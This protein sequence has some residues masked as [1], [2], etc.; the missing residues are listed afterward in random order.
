MDRPDEPVP[1]WPA[2]GSL[3]VELRPHP[4]DLRRGGG[5]ATGQGTAVT[6]NERQEE[7]DSEETIEQ[8]GDDAQQTP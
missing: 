5:H 4:R 7:E 3:E 6:R 2:R 8:H 1:V